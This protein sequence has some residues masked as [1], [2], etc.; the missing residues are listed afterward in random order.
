MIQRKAFMARLAVA[1]LAPPALRA[2]PSDRL[3]RIGQLTP[4][5]RLN[6]VE[7]SRLAT[8]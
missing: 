2:Q 4:S 5:E 1:L 7:E 3:I 8:L 6:A